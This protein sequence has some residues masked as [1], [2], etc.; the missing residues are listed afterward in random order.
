MELLYYHKQALYMVHL[1]L[2]KF[3]DYTLF[4]FYFSFLYFYIEEIIMPYRF[5]AVNITAWSIL[6]YP[7]WSRSVNRHLF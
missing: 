3:H 5:R 6:S 1:K 2:S 4:L 7:I